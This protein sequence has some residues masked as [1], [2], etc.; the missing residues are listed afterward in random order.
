[1]ECRGLDGKSNW[2]ANSYHPQWY[3]SNAPWASTNAVNSG[4]TGNPNAIV[5]G[6]AMEVFYWSNSTLMD[7]HWDATNGW[8]AAP[9]A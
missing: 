8:S 5:R 2:K 3:W 1:M 4:A 7:A 9:A 6:T